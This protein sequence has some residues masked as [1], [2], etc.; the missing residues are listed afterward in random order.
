MRTLKTR[1]YKKQSPEMIIHI[2]GF[3]D[4]H[5]QKEICDEI[6]MLLHKLRRKNFKGHKIE[7]KI[8]SVEHKSNR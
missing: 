3:V 5:E 4:E 7:Y 8:K 1:S 2:N 6:R